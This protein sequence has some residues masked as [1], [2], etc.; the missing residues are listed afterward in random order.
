MKIEHA[1][2]IFFEW[3]KQQFEEAILMIMNVIKQ[4]HFIITVVVILVASSLLNW[5]F[6][7]WACNWTSRTLHRRTKHR[8]CYECL[9]YIH[10]SSSTVKIQYMKNRLKNWC[11]YEL[12][13]SLRI[14]QKKGHWLDTV[15][16][17]PGKIQQRI[18]MPI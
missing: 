10:R 1:D 6:I 5:A 2:K 14:S 11:H 9:F 15:L 13:R 4:R 12:R 16:L 17:V 7:C 8:Y 3:W 18:T